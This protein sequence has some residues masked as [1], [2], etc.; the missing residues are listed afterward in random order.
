MTRQRIV[1]GNSA[2]SR[3]GLA[4]F[5]VL[6]ALAVRYAL[7]PLLG[8]HA[9]YLPFTLAVIAAARLGGRGPAFVATALSTLAVTYFFIAPRY[10]FAIADAGLG[11]GLALFV[12]V[13]ISVSFLVGR[14]REAL[15]ANT[16]AAEAMRRQ[17]QLINLSR[18]AIIT[19]DAHRLI[20]GWN[21]GAE[22]VY[23]WTEAEALGKAVHDLLQSRGHLSAAEIDEILA[24]E[25]HWDGE[26][27]HTA[28][29]GREV[30]TECRL[31]LVRDANGAP[32]SLLEISRD[33]TVRKRAQKQLAEAHRR[34]VSILESISDGFISFDREWRYTY[35]NAAAA[36]M[37]CKTG[38]ELLGRRFWDVWPE[39]V[40]SPFGVAFRRAVAENTPVQVEGLYPRLDVWLEVR[41]YPSNE[42]LTLFFTN[43]TERRRSQERLQQKQKLE[44]IGLLAS[45][46]AHDFN[47][48]LTV[49][50]GSAGSVLNERPTCEHSRSILEASRRA[51]YLTN[52]LLAY[53][54]KGR[55][56][57]KA[58]DFS[59]LVSANTEL[60]RASVPR[61]VELQYDLA[62][63]LPCVD[64]DP[65]QM[66]Q[67]LM[68][69]VL[70]AGEAIP[71]KTD[72]VIQVV[73]R[74]FEVTADVASRRSEDDVTPGLF[75]CLEVNDNGSGMDPSTLS[76]IFDPFFSTKFTGRG[77]GLAAVHGI[78]RAS[79]GFIE[80]SS[81]PD[82]GTHFQ[83]FLPASD[84]RRPAA[85]GRSAS[86][87]QTQ[88][89]TT[90][91][92][93]D[94]EEM[95]R[96]LACRAL[97]RCGYSLLEAC[98][99]KEA[100]EILADASPLPSLVVLDGA[101]PVMGS[102]EVLPILQERYPNLP[103]ILSSGHPEHAH[104]GVPSRSLIG[105][106]KKPYTIGELTEKVREA[107]AVRSV[108][109]A[110]SPSD[111]I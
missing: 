57:V 101:M 61:R 82:A 96:K 21:T 34:T 33:I 48:I 59:E 44:S 3:Y 28:R 102:D 5:F 83:V 8:P 92:V 95:V 58:L 37:A 36:K 16:R 80:V 111:F 54:G 78:V 4:V 93:V 56:F 39:A 63:D 109:A 31:V 19:A 9:P 6:V 38:G 66:E 94:D 24:S 79:K 105:F 88:Q 76:R 42:G 43:T 108:H 77:L 86:Q 87:L 81:Q 22:K 14:L 103:V 73:T 106:L 7:D 89:S 41:C 100:L 23:G 1:A 45:G 110:R 91:L 97:R 20:T 69:L 62:S 11:T 2:A 98:N 85:P 30:L 71:P 75:V 65:S 40:D 49:I 67:I 17:I 15:I 29:D 104:D 60:L 32:S 74:R 70:N 99:G 52:Q 72:G 90:I 51:G 107:L 26:I 18:D 84:Q 50:M 64:A 10:S 46:I 68:N 25:G 53:A 47:N 55:L 12:I 27:I 13:A 35:I